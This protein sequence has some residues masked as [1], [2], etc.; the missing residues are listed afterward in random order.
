MNFAA[1]EQVCETR[2]LVRRIIISPTIPVAAES[3]RHF[4]INAAIGEMITEAARDGF[5]PD[6][7]TTCDADDSRGLV[8]N[9]TMR[10][11]RPV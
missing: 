10:F 5:S 8:T 6:D 9:I 2:E 7:T 11:T 4:A 3:R 1:V